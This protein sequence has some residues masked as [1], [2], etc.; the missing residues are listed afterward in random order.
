MKKTLLVMISSLC[1]S[2]FAHEGHGYFG[3]QSKAT[4]VPDSRDIEIAFSPDGGAQDLVLKVIHS[5]RSSIQVMAYSFTSPSVTKALIQAKKRGVK[6]E[7][8]VDHKH[9]LGSEAR[10]NARSALNSL[11]NNGIAVRASHQFAISHDKVIIVDGRHVQTGSFNYS[12]A[13]AES[14]SENVLVVWNDAKVAK[15]YEQHWRSRWI[16]GVPYYPAY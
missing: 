7:L 11:I 16:S 8:L 15:S 5:S 9:N 14:N 1:I 10:G 4:E 2:A 3:S 6:V 13:A 12:K